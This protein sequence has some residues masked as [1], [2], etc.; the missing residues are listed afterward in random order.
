MTPVWTVVAPLCLA[1]AATFVWVWDS[2][3][4]PDS[5]YSHGPLVV[6]LAAWL[7]WADRGRLREARGVPDGRA[8]WLLGPALLLHL[9]GA[10]LTIDS[11]SAASLCLAIPGAVWLGWG[12]RC[13]RAA[14]PLLL[15][16]WFAVPM[17]LVVTGKIAFELKEVAVTAG[18]AIA[19]AVGAGV[20]R[21]GTEIL[22][23]G[24]S[25]PLVVADACSGLRSLVALTTL[26]YCFAFFFGSQSGTRRLVV[27]AL[28]VPIAVAGNI[29]RIAVICW[30][31]DQWGVEFAAGVGHDVVNA[32]VW[33][34]ALGLLIALDILLMRLRARGGGT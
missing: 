18:L 7:A 13:A 2:W 34:V 5:Y 31:A 15:L 30:A 25:Q 32:L 10:A 27:L 6:L 16:P 24:Q 1:Y 28:A 22:V 33:V 8:F 3:M 20:H 17:P 29:L 23:A 19:D 21:S 4:L 9:G 14:L 11:L 12:R 26:G